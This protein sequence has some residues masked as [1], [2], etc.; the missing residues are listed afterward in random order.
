MGKGEREVVND[1]RPLTACYVKSVPLRQA[2][3]KLNYLLV[4]MQPQNATSED[5]FIMKLLKVQ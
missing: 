5:V 4:D 3:R 2:I 1:V